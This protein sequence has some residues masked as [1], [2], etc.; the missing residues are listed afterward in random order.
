MER[1]VGKSGEAIDVRK[2][3]VFPYALLKLL[4]RCH[5]PDTSYEKLAEII[6]TDPVLTTKFFAVYNFPVSREKLPTSNLKQLLV[7]MGLD[8][9]KSIAVTSAVNQMFSKR[10]ESMDSFVE[11]FWSK[12]LKSAYVAEQIAKAIQYEPTDE[13]YFC[14]LLHRIGQL[15]LQKKTSGGYAKLA[16]L[17][18]GER[19]DA[20]E[21]ENLGVSAAEIGAL[22]IRNW[23][24][25]SYMSDAVLF[26]NEPVKTILDASRLVKIIN[27]TSKLVSNENMIDS[28]VIE[29]GGRLFD[30]SEQQIVDLVAA[31]EDKVD[32]IT[33]VVYLP[34]AL[35]GNSVS[36][37]ESLQS[38]AQKLGIKQ[39]RREL[40][41]Q[42]RDIAMLDGARQL[43]EKPNDLDE[44]LG[45]VHKNLHMLFGI[46]RSQI[47]LYEPISD[48]LV[49]KNLGEQGSDI[50]EFKVALVPGRSLMAEAVFR[51]AI[52]HS[53]D[54]ENEKYLSILDQQLIKLCGN[55][56][57]LYVPMI[58]NQSTIGVLA[59]G[60]N[61]FS[62]SS[63]QSHFNQITLFAGE[64]AAALHRHQLRNQDFRDILDSERGRRD[65]RL[66]ELIHEAGNPLGIINNYLEILGLQL[67]EEHPAQEQ[68]EI[69]KEEIYRVGDILTQ[70]R[71]TPEKEEISMG[72]M[73]LNGFITD[74]AKIFRASIS[75]SNAVDLELDLDKQL[76]PVHSN[77]NSLKQIL[78]NLIK[79]A[80][81]AIEGIGK[82]TIST[83][84]NVNVDGK[85]YVEIIVADNGPGVSDN[86][87]AHLFS[88]VTSMKGNGHS[89]LGLTIVRNL[90][91][92]LHGSISCRTNK[93][94]G[95]EFRILIPC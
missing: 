85:N 47:F 7:T 58:Y 31:A 66:R 43:L 39:V 12:S 22:L 35:N 86:V 15:V 50:S 48:S 67:G 24:S 95:T 80:S 52:V 9:I 57:I 46:K 38:D 54:A 56:A 32:H 25:Q 70:M 29:D 93:D 44:I 89:G 26:Q 88:P 90:V 41:R 53:I 69:I 73:D 27:L 83:R 45:S 1:P 30:F 64:V 19:R 76:E 68:L 28:A 59:I 6:Q 3:P 55:E 63:L 17:D 82:I 75:A 40:T 91:T 74:L 36:S 18:L 87:M 2:L 92:E 65:G 13:A 84:G 21:R 79:N 14:G 62:L 71:E 37:N 16:S 42:V 61:S 10:D 11:A 81:E 34:T 33:N 51:K 5:R 94:V 77:R 49:G 23:D 20:I 60:I 4:E 8:T 78:T 72:M